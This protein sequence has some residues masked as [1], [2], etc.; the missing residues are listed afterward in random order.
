[1]P[2][3]CGN[4]KLIMKPIVAVG[5]WT[6]MEVPWVPERVLRYRLNTTEEYSL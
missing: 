6:S 3:T 2:L 5:R 4:D 1:M